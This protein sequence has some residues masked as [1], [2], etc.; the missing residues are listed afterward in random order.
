MFHMD[1][2]KL[3]YSEEVPSLNC[4]IGKCKRCGYMSSRTIC[5][6]CTLLNKLNEGLPTCLVNT[7]NNNLS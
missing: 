2:F 3:E 5:K 6:A 7:Y 1:N 4:D